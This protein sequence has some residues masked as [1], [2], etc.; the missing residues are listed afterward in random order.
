MTEAQFDRM[1]HHEFAINVRETKAVYSRLFEFATTFHSEHLGELHTH[2]EETH[3]PT[4]AR[5]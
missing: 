5:L 4:E 1:I 3:W 2:V